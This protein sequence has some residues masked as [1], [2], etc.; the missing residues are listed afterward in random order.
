LAAAGRSV[1]LGQIAKV[2]RGH[3]PAQIEHL[4]GNRVVTVDELVRAVAMALGQPVIA[5]VCP[6]LDR[7]RDTIISI[8]ELVTAVRNALSGCAG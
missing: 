8:D 3:G 7:N 6:G 5:T 4:D 2:K 1:Q